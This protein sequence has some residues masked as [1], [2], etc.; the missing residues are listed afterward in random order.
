MVTLLGAISGI[1]S[2]GIGV[3]IIGLWIMLITKKKIPELKTEPIT[4]YFHITAEIT[5]GLMAVISGIFILLELLWSKYLFLISSGICVYAVIN[6]AG[7]YAQRKTW[8]FVGLFTV[9]LVTSLTLSILT[10]YSL[11]HL[12]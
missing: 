1:Y 3:A 2:I 5:M 6:S 12:V 11:I 7:Y 10:I 9:I 4:I 8:V